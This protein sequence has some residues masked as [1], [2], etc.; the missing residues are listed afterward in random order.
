MVIDYNVLK[1]V[2]DEFDHCD[3]N[4]RPEFADAASP[5]TAENI[6][7]VLARTLQA[8]AGPRVSI[9]EVIVRETPLTC[10]RWRKSG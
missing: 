10:A 3:L 6:A 2:I 4:A 1:H 8:K 5:T 7:L 9:D